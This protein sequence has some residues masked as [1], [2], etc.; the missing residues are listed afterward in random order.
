MDGGA[1][2]RGRRERAA[3]RLVAGMAWL[4]A[5]GLAAAAPAPPTIQV[6]KPV[7]DF[8]TVPEGEKIRH[9]FT[10][11]NTGG[12]PLEIKS[13]SAACGCTAAAPREKVIPPGGSGQIEVS[14]DTRNRPGANDKT[15]TVV[16]SDPRTPTLQLR[17]R[18]EV[19]SMVG[20]EPAYTQLEAVIGEK[21][22]VETW[23]RGKLA[24]QARPR[25]THIDPPAP[26][27]A[28]AIERQ[29][30]AGKQRGLRLAL[31]GRQI[32]QG[33]ARLR[34]ATGLPQVPEVEHTVIWTVR[35]N[36]EAPPHVHLNLGRAG[37]GERLIPVTSR[38]P[39][40][41]LKSARILQGPFTATV[42]EPAAGSTQRS[43]KVVST[44]TAT[45]ATY[46]T[47]KLLLES[48]DP[49]EPRKEVSLSVSA[50]APP[51]AAAAPPAP[52]RR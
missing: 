23:L 29:T 45:T 22:A 8:G 34:I 44:L 16:S 21:R 42:L 40:F 32:A 26:L 51:P 47:G 31:Q 4:V 39:D 7:H 18:A 43:I 11:K 10:V 41:R 13:V 14:F 50:P 38:R 35:G 17:I 3:V 9:L 5:A 24:S 46:A 12:T 28:E 52:A 20:L 6:D 36:I 19:E 37:G 48:N 33:N 1:R 27:Q 30:A 49:L 15:V 2:A 25:V